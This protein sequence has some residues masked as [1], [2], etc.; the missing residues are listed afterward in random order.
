[1]NKA[2]IISILT[3]VAGSAFATAFFL[4]KTFSDE[5][6]KERNRKQAGEEFLKELKS[7]KTEVAP[8]TVASSDRWENILSAG[9]SAAVPACDSLVLLWD[10]AM[11]PQVSAYF[12][13]KKAEIM[14]D[15]SVWT[16]AGKRF[17]AVSAF[18][19]DG[20]RGWAI[21]NAEYAFGKALEID[22]RNTDARIK[23]A[24]SI[25]E[26]G[27]EPMKGIA[28][29]R[30]ISAEQPS[31]TEVMMELGRFAMISAQFE[32]AIGHFTQ[33]VRTD[34]TISEARFYLAD[35]YAA[36]G[37]KDSARVQLNLYLQKVPAG[38][39]MAQ[40]AKEYM[41]STYWIE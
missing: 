16:E 14:N 10:K 25:V 35:A 22:P 26:K 4:P 3:L 2:G 33:V 19:G 23:L 41:K 31:N 12:F 11:F 9:G 28:M 40:Q 27:A 36:S 24:A 37:K 29:L 39:V 34:S 7:I 13:G 6:V 38:N 18:S 21:D 5:Q 32:K 15:A 8:Q 17:L 30:E 20:N 1:M